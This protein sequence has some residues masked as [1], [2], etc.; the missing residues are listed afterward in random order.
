MNCGVEMANNL[1]KTAVT[2]AATDSIDP[3]A[4]DHYSAVDENSRYQE[5]RDRRDPEES[6]GVVTVHPENRRIQSAIKQRQSFMHPNFPTKW[7]INCP[8]S[9]SQTEHKWM[10]LIFEA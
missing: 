10:G 1:N 8:T 5:V 6:V 3:V 7:I 9:C 2:L 4:A